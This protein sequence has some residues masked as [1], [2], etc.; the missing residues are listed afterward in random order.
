MSVWRIVHNAVRTN[1][2]PLPVAAVVASVAAGLALP[3]LD[4]QIDRH[5]RAWPD[6]VLFGGDADAARTLLDAISSSLITVTSLT[7]S[8]TVV[9]L[10][11]A[12]SQFSPRLLRTFTRDRFVQVTLA[13]FLATFAFS[14]TVMR[15]IRNG[16]DAGGQFVPRLSITLAFLLA[17]ASV[18]G[19]VLFL[20]HLTREIRVETMLRNVHR[21]ARENIEHLTSPLDTASPAQTEPT[22]ALAATAHERRSGDIDI[23]SA[24]SGFLTSIDETRLVTTAREA[25]AIVVI[26]AMPGS[27]LIHGVP[28]GY[29]RFTAAPDQAALDAFLDAVTASVHTGFERTEPQDI[30]YGLQQLTDVAT[31]ALS[32]GIND[33]TTAVHALSHS[34]A[35]LCELAHRQLGAVALHDDHQ[36]LRVV[37]H[38]P[39]LRDLLDLALGQPRRYGAADLD[40]ARRLYGLLDDLTHHVSQEHVPAISEQLDQLRHATSRQGFDDT[41]H[42]D[43]AAWD[44]QV[45]ARL[46]RL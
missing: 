36:V 7:F 2:W 30:A 38:R 35:L 34:S 27:S 17:L 10:Q 15:S 18:I 4:R 1:L 8:L 26:T 42:A 32:P 46:A 23:P 6:P 21:D 33:P 19:L 37:L 22:T 11:L 31:K 41:E 20:A 5:I 40:V 12:S 43:L 16:D 14:L 44:H 13:L 25:Q 39:D 28:L 3:A 9:T 29:A 45:R 24:T